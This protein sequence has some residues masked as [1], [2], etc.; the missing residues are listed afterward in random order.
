MNDITFTTPASYG[1]EIRILLAKETYTCEGENG[2]EKYTIS[3]QKWSVGTAPQ[4]A[5]TLAI[6]VALIVSTG[7]V[8]LHIKI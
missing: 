8:T 3:T 2:V 1:N 4:K 7:S 6:Q 5:F